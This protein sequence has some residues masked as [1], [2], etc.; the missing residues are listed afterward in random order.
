MYC[1]MLLSKN[2][3]EITHVLQNQI[4]PIFCLQTNHDDYLPI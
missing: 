2:G 1:V 3:K 4:G